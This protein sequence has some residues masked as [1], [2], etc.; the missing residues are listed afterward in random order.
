[1]LRMRAVLA[2]LGCLAAALGG[3]A[4]A[5]EAAGQK[6]A[7]LRI[8]HL[9]DCHAATATSNPRPRFLL[10]LNSKDLVASF[11]LLEAAVRDLNET[12]KP[13]L[14]VV[15]GDLTDRRGDLASLQRVKAILGKLKAPYCPVIGNHDDRATWQRVFGPQRLNYTFAHGGW[16]FIAVDASAGR[17]DEATMAWLARELRADAATP[18][19]LLLH[20]PAAVPEVF[21]GLA[22]R[23]YGVSLLLGNSAEV[24]KLL[25]GAPNVRSV[26]AGHC[27]LPMESRVGGTAHL[28][29]PCL[30]GPAHL[31]R[32]VELREGEVRS[33]LRSIPLPARV[34]PP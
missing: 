19:V 33:E 28:V 7:P 34:R 9:T 5:G 3:A 18:T 12:V 22:R 29:T 8:A 31:F 14:V 23:I 32:V 10:D 26:L 16:R 11:Q 25:A 4:A 17:L 21:I 13:D 15:T 24:L 2:F 6:P 30:I 1:M 20:W 27:H